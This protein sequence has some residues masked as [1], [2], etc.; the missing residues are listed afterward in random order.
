MEKYFLG[1]RRARH[2]ESQYTERRNSALI[3]RYYY[4]SEIKRLRFDDVTSRL[5]ATFFLS[6]GYI[7]TLLGQSAADFAA[8]C[9]SR[10]TRESLRAE[11]P[12]FDWN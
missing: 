7:M 6:E 8:I 9:N 1:Y 12:E 11:W 4:L 3:S 2:V 10:P 5:A